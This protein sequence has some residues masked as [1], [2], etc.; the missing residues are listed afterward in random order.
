VDEELRI[1][2]RYLRAVLR[3]WW[4]LV[5][6]LLLVVTDVIERVFGTWLLPSSRVKMAVG[7]TVFVIAQYRV[8]RD[9]AISSSPR[10]QRPTE[11][12]IYPEQGSAMYIETPAAAAYSIG[13]Y[14]VFNLTVQNRGPQNSVVRRFD[15][16]VEGLPEKYE[17][18]EPIRRN[19]IQTRSAQMMMQGSILTGTSLLV[20]AHNVWSG[21]LG[22]YL[23]ALPINSS[24]VT[25]ILRLVDTN[26]TSAQHTFTVRVVD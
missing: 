13:T 12:V 10:V 7:V 21:S 8:Y 26:A 16:E 25:C 24:E 22:L 19:F 6:E 2:T 9:L 5:I 15:L 1:V 3:E 18:V 23:G 11:L 20:P 14:F 4:A 17:S